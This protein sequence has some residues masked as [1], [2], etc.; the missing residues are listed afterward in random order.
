MALSSQR[1]QQAEDDDLHP[2]HHHE[3]P[4]ASLP[5]VSTNKNARGE[6]S[7]TEYYEIDRLSS[8]VV[9]LL[10]V[11]RDDHSSSSSS[12]FDKPAPAETNP[13]TAT[14]PALTTPPPTA[15]ALSSSSSSSP[16]LAPPLF[17]CRVALQFPDELLQD[18]PQVVWEMEQA[19]Q[20]KWNMAMHHHSQDPLLSTPPPSICS[21]LVFILGDTTFGPCCPDEIAA[22]HLQAHVLIHYGHACLSSSSSSR[23][24][25]KINSSTSLEPSSQPSQLPVLYSFGKSPPD[26]FNVTH[27]VNTVLQQLQSQQQRRFLLLYQVQYHFAMEDLQTQLSER[28]D[29]LVIAGQIP[30]PTLSSSPQYYPQQQQQQQQQRQY[31]ATTTTT[32]RNKEDSPENHVM[33]QQ[34][35]QEN[36][37][38]ISTL[39]SC[40]C[41][42]SSGTS[43]LEGTTTTTSSCHRNHKDDDD[44]I[45]EQQQ[46]DDDDDIMIL[47][48]LELPRHLDWSTF[49]LLYIGDVLD[50][51]EHEH[52]GSSTNPRQHQQQQQ[53]INL[54]LRFVS[55]PPS[56]PLTPAHV[57][58]YSPQRKRLDTSLLSNNTSSS[59]HN[60][61][62][63]RILQRRFYLIQRARDASVFGIV[64]GTLS[65]Q[66]FQTVVHQLRT[67]LEQA[68][69]TVY[70]FAVGKIN[71]SKLANFAQVECFV[72]VACPEQ[73]ADLL[74]WNQQHQQR[75]GGGGASGAGGGE[76]HAPIITP[77]ELQMALGNVEWGATPYSL[78]DRDY[79]ATVPSTM[80]PSTDK[81][82]QGENDGDEDDDDDDA[83]YFS[84]VT[85]TYQSKKHSTIHT[86]TAAAAIFTN[87]SITN[88]TQ[89]HAKDSS[90]T[91]ATQTNSDTTTALSTIPDSSNTPSQQQQLVE[92]SSPAA[93]FLQ[94]RDYRGLEPQWGETP[95]QP[96]TMGRAGIASNYGEETSLSSPLLS[97]LPADPSNQE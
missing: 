15:A 70:I 28:G 62:Y 64:V 59:H 23:S 34:R 20:L 9:E 61:Y 18:A 44:K 42:S 83:P 1:Q 7:I 52:D 84:L 89:Q 10:T 6:T 45:M 50:D 13:N 86:A 51:D 36:G 57:W 74:L 77:L 5:L 40:G 11:R 58:V 79:L 53:W 73:H 54:L 14:I 85:G 67:S 19:L 81:L 78:D 48:G 49:T 21:I 22:N 8:A 93:L 92:F 68:G 27:C 71:A 72:L 43:V 66:Y 38:G 25:S 87:G 91:I 94:Q 63:S 3:L 88:T 4:A 76:Y 31:V 60:N 35:Q 80:P 41:H 17:S 82:R 2:H 24:H 47:G 55:S 16:S 75:G 29:V 46:Q 95:I 30:E 56:S 96:A 39:L 65:T 69:R 33:E 26:S 37:C 12:S 32:T 90:L 97:Q